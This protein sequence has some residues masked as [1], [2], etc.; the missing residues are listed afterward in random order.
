MSASKRKKRIVI[1]SILVLAIVVG[2]VAMKAKG[3]KKEEVKLPVKVG[4]AEIADVQVKVTETDFHITS[5]VTTFMAGTSY[6]FVVTNKG[7]TAHEFMIK[8]AMLPIE[9][10][11]RGSYLFRSRSMISKIL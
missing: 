9:M 4:K 5:S 3:G 11:S 1:L 6:H 10:G 7:Q 2:L 8:D